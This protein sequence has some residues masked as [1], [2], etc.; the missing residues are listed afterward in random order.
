M[1]KKTKDAKKAKL[2][3]ITR[4]VVFMLVVVYAA[5]MTYLVIGASAD[6]AVAEMDYLSHAG[7][8]AVQAQA[9]L[10]YAH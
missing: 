8:H 10:S 2:L 5:V 6:A 3:K 9:M 4:D 7:H 1:T